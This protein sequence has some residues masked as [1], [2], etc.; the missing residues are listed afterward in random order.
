MRFNVQILESNKEI[1]NRILDSMLNPINKIISNGITRIKN[2]LPGVVRQAIISTPEY[3]SLSQGKLKYEFGINNVDSKLASLINVWSTNI[4]YE[5]KKPIVSNNRIICS[6]SASMIRADF[7]DVL[8]SE[9]S[10]VQDTLRGYSL[11]WL[12]WLLLEGNKTIVKN[13][14]VVFGQNKASRTGFAIMRQSNRSWRVPPEF[15]GTESD[16]WITRA[17]D[18]ARP[19]IYSILEEAF[20]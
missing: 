8:Y 12:Q 10:S 18:N 13:H 15:A 16:N 11:P 3:E 20:K 6:F 7:S 2:T 17:I 4:L 1:Q 9:F 19:Q 14:E 5:Y